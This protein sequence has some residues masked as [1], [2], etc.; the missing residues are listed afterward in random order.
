MDKCLK[1]INKNNIKNILKAID[2]HD[3]L[4]E[5]DYI[6]MKGLVNKVIRLDKVESYHYEYLDTIV[7]DTLIGII[8]EELYE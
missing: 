6:G 1:L 4:K 7:I 5:I 2:K 3:N 8:K